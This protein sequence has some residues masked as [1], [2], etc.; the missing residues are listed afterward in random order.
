M[1][2]DKTNSISIIWC[3]DDVQMQLDSIKERDWFIKRY[4]SCVKLTH[5][6]CMDILG[7]IK[8]HHDATLGVSW[9]TLEHHICEFLDEEIEEL[10]FKP[11]AIPGT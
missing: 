6:D 4:G 7:D 9:D 10:P 1:K 8:S 11:I 5:E 2:Y 3:V